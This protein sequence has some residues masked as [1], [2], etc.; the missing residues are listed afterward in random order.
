L[1]QFKIFFENLPQYASSLQYRFGS[2]LGDVQISD[3]I[4][5]AIA[6]WTSGSIVVSGTFGIFNGFVAAI[7]VLVIS[8][9]LIAE[10]QG[11]KTF[12]G[13]LIPEQHR[14]F[15]VTVVEKIQ[16]KMGLWVLGQG[17]V[18]LVMFIITWI[19]LSLLHV[20]YALI[21]AVVAGLLEVVP[22]IGPFIAAVPAVLIALLVS[23]AL[24]LGVLVLYFL[25]HEFEAN[26]L[27]PKVM[28]KTVGTSPLAVLLALLI[29]YKL[30]G[31]L[32]IIM[33][34]PL[35]G[36]LTVVIHEFY[37]RKNA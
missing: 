19:G 37:S 25:L 8:F 11:M 20:P 10:E 31:V 34:V 28:E 21:L 3:Y 18:S 9:Y 17:I 14:E 2:F 23:P 4:V 26:I 7:S 13:T 16:K 30:A 35:V 32:G 27:V 12:L 36:A 29:G 6:G 5:Q 33:S 24:A 15:I 22:Y 1:E